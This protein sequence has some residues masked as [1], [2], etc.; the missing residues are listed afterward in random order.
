MPIEIPNIGFMN[1][2]NKLDID[3][4]EVHPIF[5]NNPLIRPFGIKGFASNGKLCTIAQNY[6]LPMHVISK[7]R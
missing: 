4:V 6:V 1:N 5:K 2:L 7:N 3:S